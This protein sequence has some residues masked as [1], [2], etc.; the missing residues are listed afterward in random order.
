MSWEEAAKYVVREMWVDNRPDGS[1]YVVM[2]VAGVRADGSYWVN[3]FNIEIPYQ[4]LQAMTDTELD[5]LVR[6]AIAK[7]E[8]E[9]KKWRDIQKQNEADTLLLKTSQKYRLIIGR[10][11]RKEATATF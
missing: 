2:E 11:Y 8:A 3:S 7:N 9:L 10:E 5:K 1:K 6:D 4:Q